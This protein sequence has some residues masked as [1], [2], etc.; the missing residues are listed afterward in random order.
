MHVLNWFHCMAFRGR[1]GKPVSKFVVNAADMPESDI[2]TIFTFVVL[3]S[4]VESLKEI[5][6]LRSPSR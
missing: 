4:L 6:I 2:N 5:E 3:D 1:S